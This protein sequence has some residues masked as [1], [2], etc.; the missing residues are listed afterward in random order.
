V[1]EPLLRAI[2]PAGTEYSVY[3]SVFGK[4]QLLIISLLFQIILFLLWKFEW[5]VATLTSFGVWL[6]GRGDQVLCCTLVWDAFPKKASKHEH[7]TSHSALRRMRTT[8]ATGW[9]LELPTRR[10]TVRKGVDS[11]PG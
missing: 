8:L 9:T 4:Y 3:V 10:H 2:Y 11:F 7:S 1:R 6:V 5:I